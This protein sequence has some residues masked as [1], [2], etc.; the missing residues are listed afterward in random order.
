MGKVIED[1]SSGNS[2]GFV[3]FKDWKREFSSDKNPLELKGAR[4]PDMFSNKK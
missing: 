3:I 1:P 4:S 2:R